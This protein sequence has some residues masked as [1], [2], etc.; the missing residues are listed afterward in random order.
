MAP[1]PSHPRAIIFDLDGTLVDAYA[2]IHESLGVVLEAFGR[3]PVAR[4]ETRRMVG[5][6]LE[7]LVAKAVGEENVAEGVRLFRERYE[8]VGLE[9]TRL[10]PGA[11]LVTRSLFEKGIRLAIAS[12]KPARFTRPLLEVLGLS[13]RFGFVAGPDDGFPPKP[14]PHMVFM[15]LATLAVPARDAVFVGDMPID[16]A[17]ARAAQLPIIALP[18][19]SATRKELEACCP[20]AIVENLEELLPFLLAS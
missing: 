16:V 8:R 4:D 5:H 20:D 3:P 10:L 18:T 15:A 6:G 12:N 1:L 7:V 17:T 13:S 11:E 9:S 14:A 19:G 2:A